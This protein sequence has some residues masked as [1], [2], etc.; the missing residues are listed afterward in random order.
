MEL[1]WKQEAAKL[2][3]IVN[4]QNKVLA[5]IAKETEMAALA[6]KALNNKCIRLQNENTRLVGGLR[7]AAIINSA[8]KRNHRIGA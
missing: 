7:T 6:I 4:E 5:D 1:Y 3:N 2:Q 8:A